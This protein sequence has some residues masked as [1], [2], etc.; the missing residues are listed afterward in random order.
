MIATVILPTWI[1]IPWVLFLGSRKLVCTST[2][3]EMLWKHVAYALL[4]SVMETVDFRQ[5]WICH[6]D[7]AA[8]L[9]PFPPTPVLR[10]S[11]CQPEMTGF[12]APEKPPKHI[13]AVSKMMTWA[14]FR[15]EGW[16]IA[17]QRKNSL[18]CLSPVLKLD[19]P[20]PSQE[21]WGWQNHFWHHWC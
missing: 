10:A 21:S 16:P 2:K 5:T 1:R 7:P 14:Q 3:G 6:P 13:T 17:P 8:C 12:Q 18:F 20:A 9:L 15:T 11:Q 19:P 4:L